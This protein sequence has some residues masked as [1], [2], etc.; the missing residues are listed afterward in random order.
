MSDQPGLGHA[1]G[2]L[3]EPYGS[4]ERSESHADELTPDASKNTGFRLA[5]GFE[6]LSRDLE[7]TARIHNTYSRRRPALELPRLDSLT[8]RAK[9]LPVPAIVGVLED[10]RVRAVDRGVGPATVDHPRVAGH[11]EAADRDGILGSPAAGRAVWS[12][13]G[14]CLRDPVVFESG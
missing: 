4:E 9:P 12:G 11:H 1:D 10:E 3:P 13:S 7:Q 2:P 8:K 6:K 14:E 5:P